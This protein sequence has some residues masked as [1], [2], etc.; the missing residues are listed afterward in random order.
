MV[1]LVSFIAPAN[2]HERDYLNLMIRHSENELSLH[3]D[4][5]VGDMSYIS[6]EQKMHLRKQSNTAVL[7]RVRENMKPPKEYLDYGCPECSE[8]IPLCWD[9]Y[10]V[11]TEMHCYTNPL[12]NPAC[13]T[14][15]QHGNCYQELYVSPSIDEHHFGMIP[16][17]TKLAQKLLQKIRPQVERGFENDKNKLHLNRFFVN[18]IKLANILGQLSDACQILLL[19][20]DMRT[21]TKA[22]AKKMMKNLYTQMTFDFY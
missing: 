17:H 5:I 8:G 18:S 1:P 3:I 2:I 19:L 10:D 7:T 9:A 6:S 15:W 13:D 12:D 22:K 11:E 4:I 16:L 20:G 21:N 14:C